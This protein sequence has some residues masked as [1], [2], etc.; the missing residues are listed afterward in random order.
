MIMW[1]PHSVLFEVSWCVML[2]TTVLAIDVFIWALER[3]RKHEWWRF[4][5]A[6][7]CS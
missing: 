2:Y 4:S 5:A 1:N 6:S 3:W 7:T